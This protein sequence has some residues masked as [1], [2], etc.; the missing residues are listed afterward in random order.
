MLLLGLTSSVAASAQT[1][2]PFQGQ[3]REVPELT[4]SRVLGEAAAATGSARGGDALGLAARLAFGVVPL[5][6]PSSGFQLKLDPNTGLQ[7]RTSTTFGPAFA[8]RAMTSGEGTVTAAVSY[9]STNLKRLDDGVFDGTRLRAVTATA[10]RDQRNATSNLTMT[11]NTVVVAARMGV[12]DNLDVGVSVPMTTVRVGGSTTLTDGAGNFLAHAAAS[13]VNKGVGDVSGIIKYRFV[14]FGQGQPDPGGLAFMV[15]M[16]LPTGSKENL[17]GLG[18]TRTQAALIASGGRGRFRPHANVGFEYW[19]KGVGVVSD[20][21][22]TLTEARHALQ[23]AAGFELEA[24]P[25][26]TLLA[27]V[28]GGQIYG[29]GRLGQAAIAG[30]P[31]TQGLVA[32][33]EGLSR[34]ILA[35]GVKVN[36]KSKLLLTVNALVTLKDSG[37]HSRV[38]TVAGL[39]VTF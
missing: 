38:T 26:A 14:A 9:M 6:V 22:N 15:S 39:D 1:G 21:T 30:A 28:L 36:I 23:Y 16:R 32:L 19:D 2:P 17:R 34:V 20:A 12:T 7:V 27:D 24:A 25:K 11:A 33:D 13:G 5:I 37:L 29:G 31:N 10:A 35:P 3:T 8:E 18:V 4:M